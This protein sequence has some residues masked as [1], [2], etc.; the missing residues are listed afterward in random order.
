VRV[1]SRPLFS[2]RL[3]LFFLLKGDFTVR[4]PCLSFQTAAIVSVASPACTPLSCFALYTTFS[5]SSFE[6]PPVPFPPLLLLFL[7]GIC[8]ISVVSPRKGLFFFFGPGRP[9]LAG[10]FFTYLMF[11]RRFRLR[12]LVLFCFSLPREFMK[13]P[14]FVPL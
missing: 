11:E 2:V 14:F 13:Y 1:L 3:Q 8:P 4:A 6:P 12:S 9:P 7:P 5:L 10:F